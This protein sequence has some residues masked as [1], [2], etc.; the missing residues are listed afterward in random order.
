MIM[1][2]GIETLKFPE[3][4]L[5]PVVE[6]PPSPDSKTTEEEFFDSQ[7]SAQDILKLKNLP[8]QRPVNT[9]TRSGDI[10]NDEEHV[11]PNTFL[12]SL[13]EEEPHRSSPD[14]KGKEEQCMNEAR[15]SMP[16]RRRKIPS[17]ARKILAT[18]FEMNIE[19]PYP[20]DD[21]REE[22][23]QKTG[24]THKQIHHWFTNRRKRDVQWRARY[25]FRGR[26]RRP[27]KLKKIKKGQRNP[28]I[29]VYI[30]PVQF[31]Q[32]HSGPIQTCYIP[33]PNVYT[34]FHPNSHR[35][36]ICQQHLM[37]RQTQHP[38]LT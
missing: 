12:T 10:K 2:P 26:G 24:L 33:H 25:L 35:G 4:H 21:E 13:N 31:S 18:W 36:V 16:Q 34:S 1:E 37:P 17:E 32:A 8:R 5:G 14:G 11:D 23:V 38:R 27:K 3:E 22:L 9:V 19:D 15:G 30:T 20:S 6:F 28:S 29:G 7:L